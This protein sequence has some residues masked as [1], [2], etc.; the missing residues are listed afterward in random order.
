[1]FLNIFNKFKYLL[2]NFFTGCNLLVLLDQAIRSSKNKQKMIKFKNK[3]NKNKGFALVSAVFILVI[4]AMMSSFIISISIISNK[5]TEFSLQGTR[6]YF[7]AK[8]GLDWGIKQII[9]NPTVCPATTALSLTQGGLKGFVSTV[10]CSATQYTE[11]S[12]TFNVFNLTALATKGSF[13]N[14]DYVSRQMQVSVT[15]GN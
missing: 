3:K 7:A 8:T 1:M 2:F 15:I 9:S 14:V 5:T 4:L 13:G 12:S 11:G 10:S 6:A